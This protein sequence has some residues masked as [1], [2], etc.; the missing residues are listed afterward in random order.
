VR[1]SLEHVDFVRCESAQKS[2]A[3]TVS[4]CMLDGLIGHGAAV[5]E[6]HFD[7]SEISIPHGTVQ[8]TTYSTS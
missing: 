5:D 7:D 2:G 8:G 6:I 4:E 1:A 3:R